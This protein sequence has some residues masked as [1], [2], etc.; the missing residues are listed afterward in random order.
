MQKPKNLIAFKKKTSMI[1][2]HVFGL[3]D[4]LT[5]DQ[6]MLFFLDVFKG[7]SLAW[8]STLNMWS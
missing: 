5:S 6:H 2:Y 7:F 4:T 1:R 3:L 8:Y